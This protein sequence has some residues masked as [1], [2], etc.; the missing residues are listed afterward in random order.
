MSD[1]YTQTLIVYFDYR[2][3]LILMKLRCYGLASW[4]L[5][6]FEFFSVL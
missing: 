1:I 4:F 6:M 3:S 2:S 5:M